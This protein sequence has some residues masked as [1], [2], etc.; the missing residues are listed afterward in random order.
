MKKI[1]AIASGK[2]GVGKSTLAANLAAYLANHEVGGRPPLKV[3]L[4]DVDFYGPS[5]PTLMGAK[6]DGTE[7]KVDHQEKFIPPLKHGVKYISIAFFLKNNDDPIIWRGPMFGKAI[8][9]L[10]HDVS[11]GEVDICLVDMPPGTGDAQLSL[12]QGVKL[13]GAVLVTTPQEVALSDVRRAL[14]MFRKVNVPVLGVVEN[15]S[16]FTTPGGEQLDIFGRGGGEALATQYSVPFLGSLPIALN[17]RQGGD[18]G[19]PFGVKAEG[20]PGAKLAQIADLMLRELENAPAP[21]VVIED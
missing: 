3:A 10:F 14:N 7:L 9:Q 19:E 8:N 11:W 12:A 2:G 4:I 1:V 5:I 18:I 13:D 16:G 20:E 6:L 15:M 17:I 21:G